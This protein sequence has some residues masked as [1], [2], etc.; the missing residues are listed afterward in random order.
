MISHGPLADHFRPAALQQLE[1]P[2][3]LRTAHFKPSQTNFS[4]IASVVSSLRSQ[5]VPYLQLLVEMK[6]DSG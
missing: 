1:R 3:E 4:W 6:D 5:M 2:G